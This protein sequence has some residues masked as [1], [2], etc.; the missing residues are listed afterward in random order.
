MVVGMM[1]RNG[2]KLLMH[3][4]QANAL[5]PERFKQMISTVVVR[6]AF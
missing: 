4:T 1:G 6:E 2:V 3:N 5:E